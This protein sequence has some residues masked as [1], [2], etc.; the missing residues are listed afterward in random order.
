MS[1]ALLAVALA[2]VALQ[3]GAAVSSLLLA[4]LL[5]RRGWACARRRGPGEVEF[6]ITTKATEGVMGVL[7]EVIER[8]RRGFPGYTIWVVADHDSPGLGE[9]RLWRWELGFNLVVVPRDYRRGRYKSRA[10]QYFIDNYVDED[11]WYVFL[12]DDSYPLDDRFLCE[13]RDDVPVYNGHI[14]PRRGRSLL[15]WLADG[16]RYYN[17]I[18]RQRLA[19]GLLHKPVYGLHGELL[20]VKGWVLKRV[21]MASDSLAE[22]SLYAARLIRAGIPVGMVSTRVSILSPHSVVDFWRQRARWNLGALRDMA[23]GLY[24]PSMMAGKGVD[25]TL[26]LLAPLS[27]LFWGILAASLHGHP[28]GLEALALAGTGL[29]ALFVANHGLVAARELGPLRGLLL[30]GLSIPALTLLYYLSPV[31]ATLKA[32]ELGRRF[33][34]IEKSP[35]HQRPIEPPRESPILEASAAPPPTGVAG[36]RRGLQG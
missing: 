25:I 17:S 11:K 18:T 32:G 1:P 16:S 26:W 2:A 34:I 27:P 15:A 4:P 36:L 24:P 35:R 30:V 19:L 31:Y 7:R 14:Y 21:P 22:D 13:L 33:V 12:D 8:V 29:Y 23:R 20:I 10:I 9:L 5:A 3:V 6:V 28:H